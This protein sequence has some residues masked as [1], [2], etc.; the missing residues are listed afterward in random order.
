M[1]GPIESAKHTWSIPSIKIYQ[2]SSSMNLGRPSYNLQHQSILL[3]INIIAILPLMQG[4]LQNIDVAGLRKAHH[5]RCI[6]LF[7]NLVYMLLRIYWEC[8]YGNQ[9]RWIS[10][11][12]SRRLISSKRIQKESCSQ[13]LPCQLCLT[14]GLQNEKKRV[15]DK[16]TTSV[17]LL[18]NMLTK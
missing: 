12:I 6:H 5:G 18:F 1:S 9:S 2:T 16:E 4:I 11:K 8:D 7:I 14:K 15:H 3:E 17:Q 13:L 10:I